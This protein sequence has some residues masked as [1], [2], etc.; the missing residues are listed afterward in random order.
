MSFEAITKLDELYDL[1]PTTATG[2]KVETL[3]SVRRKVKG[4]EAAQALLQAYMETAKDG[5]ARDDFDAAETAH[6]AS[7]EP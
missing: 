5:M 3:K 6:E 1:D 4:L 7:A 2:M